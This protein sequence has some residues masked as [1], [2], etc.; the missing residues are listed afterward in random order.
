EGRRRPRAHDP[1]GAREGIRQAAGDRREDGRGRH[2]QVPRRDHAP[3]AAVREGRQADGRE[4]A[5]RA[6]GEG[7]RLPLPRRR[8][9]HREAPER[10]RRRSRRDHEERRLAMT[11]RT[12]PAKPT[13]VAGTDH[14]EAAKA[15]ANTPAQ[16]AYPRIL[17]KLSGEALMGADA[18][19]I[20][21]DTVE[22]IVR[23][24]KEV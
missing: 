15:D 13:L 20:N 4:D 18:F 22:R 7:A 9:G 24:V 5:R 2:Q 11:L 8:R 1:G 14:A 16:P 19:G 6:Q 10:L 21:R 23:E 17:L 12:P 3:R